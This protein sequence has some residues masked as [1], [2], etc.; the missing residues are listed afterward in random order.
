M[1]LYKKIDIFAVVKDNRLE[2]QCST[3]QSKTCKEAVEKFKA[4]H[5]EYDVVKAWFDK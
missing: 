5:P 4:L 1:K 2:Y 3:Q